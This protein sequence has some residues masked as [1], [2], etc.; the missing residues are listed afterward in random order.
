MRVERIVRRT[1]QMLRDGPANQARPHLVP[2]VPSRILVERDQHERIFHKLGIF[3]CRIK[4]IDKP[5]PSERCVGVMSVVGNVWRV[6]RIC[7]H[8]VVGDVTREEGGCEGC[9]L[10]FD[11]KPPRSPET[12]FADL[13]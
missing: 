2:L 6:E 8:V 12:T 3:Q 7:G 11:W 9:Q 10:G 1:L 13:V 4:E 5:R